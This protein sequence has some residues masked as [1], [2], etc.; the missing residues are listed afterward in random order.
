MRGRDDEVET[1]GNGETA[2]RGEWG[3]RS[4]HRS[5]DACAHVPSPEGEGQEEGT[6]K[7]PS[8]GESTLF[9]TASPLSRRETQ[10][11]NASSNERALASRAAVGPKSPPW[12]GRD[13]VG[14]WAT[15]SSVG[16]VSSVGPFST[17]RVPGASMAP[18]HTP[19]PES[20]LQREKDRK[21]GWDGPPSSGYL[22]LFNTA[23]PLSRGET[24]GW[25]GTSSNTSTLAPVEAAGPTSSTRRGPRPIGG[26][27]IS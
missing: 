24:G 11:S 6:E 9:N 20:L 22:T 4:A 3:C 8:P 16:A 19:G 15:R 23:S 17:G 26:D 27:L 12:R 21:R 13:R 25:P 1:W 5:R 2:R 7:P 14:R 18:A 10:G